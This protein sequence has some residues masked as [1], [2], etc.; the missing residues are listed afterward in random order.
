MLCNG[1]GLKIILSDLLQNTFDLDSSHQNKK[2]HFIETKLFLNHVNSSNHSG[3]Y[4]YRH[5]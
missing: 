1:G 2:G 3:D 5:I 4:T